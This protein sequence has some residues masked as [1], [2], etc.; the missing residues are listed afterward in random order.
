MN[1]ALQHLPTREQIVRMLAA[2]REHAFRRGVWTVIE[3]AN[4]YIKEAVV[5][6]GAGLFEGIRYFQSARG[7]FLLD[8][9]L[10]RAL[11]GVETLN[12]EVPDGYEDVGW[13]GFIFG[14]FREATL[15]TVALNP[16]MN[17]YVRPWF[18][19]GLRRTPPP[20]H[21]LGSGLHVR[22]WHPDTSHRMWTDYAVVTEHW[23]EY[24][25]GDNLVAIIYRQFE[26]PT[27]RV[28]P[29]WMKGVAGYVTGQMASDAAAKAGANE[30]M[31]GR[32]EPDGVWYNL[33][34]PGQA[35]AIVENGVFVTP[36]P[37]VAEI[38]PSTQSAW[39]TNV[40]APRLGLE[41]RYGDLT[42]ERI[43]GASELLYIGSAT[44]IKAFGELWDGDPKLGGRRHVI[45]DGRPGPIFQELYAQYQ[46]AARGGQYQ[47]DITA[48]P[49]RSYAV[50]RAASLTLRSLGQNTDLLCYLPTSLR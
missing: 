48:V 5:H 21:T 36:D 30:A 19:R 8:E 27:N 7:I 42:T 17:S 1:V 26:R 29:T 49:D 6:Y 37:R 20:P 12:F 41:V 47:K 46:L 15:L 38:L 33:D 18:G 43:A 32:T 31:M 13:R 24:I 25:S 9:H 4:L 40:V 34:G 22:A 2:D 10:E 16:G 44:G 35:I 39:F 14:D 11:V 3:A 45:G 23:P 28:L 50:E